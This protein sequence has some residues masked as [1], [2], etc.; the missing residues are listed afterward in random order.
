[1]KEYFLCKLEYKKYE[2]GFTIASII[3]DI[4]VPGI[5]IIKVIFRFIKAFWNWLD[6]AR[7]FKDAWNEKNLNKKY[8]GYGTVVG[9]ILGIFLYILFGIELL[10]PKGTFRKKKLM[11]EKRFRLM[12]KLK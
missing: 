8:E 11:K 4:L 6:V 12:K 3:A 2:I 7:Q 5:Y 10:S 9:L 1:M